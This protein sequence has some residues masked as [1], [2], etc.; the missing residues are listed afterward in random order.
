MQILAPRY[1]HKYL[2]SSLRKDDPFMDISLLTKEDLLRSIYPSIGEDALLYL[3]KEK[4]YQYDVATHYLEFLPYVKEDVNEKTHFLLSL[5]KELE[6][7]ELLISPINNDYSGLN[8]TIIGYYPNDFEL[9]NALKELNISYQFKNNELRKEEIKI[10]IFEKAEDEVYYVLNKI[11][12]LIDK[13]TSINDIYILRRNSSYDYYLRK[14][15]PKFGYQVNIKNEEK[16]SSTGAMKLF[17]SIYDECRDISTSLVKLKEDMKEDP[18]FN[19]VEDF[20]NQ[21]LD[22]ELP[23]EILRDY[24]YHKAKEKNLSSVTYD[25]AISVISKNIVSEDKII[26]VLGFAQGSYPLSFK[27]DKYFN[28]GELHK[29][30]RLNNKDKTKLDEAL[31]LD[32]FNSNNDFYFSFSKKGFESEFYLSP[33]SKYFKCE[34]EKPLLE[35]DFY[36]KEV[37]TLIYSGLKDL[38][39]Y[40]KE[41]GDN[42]LK[43]RDIIPISYNSYSNKYAYKANVYDSSSF[44][45]LSTT[46]LEKYSSCRYKFYLDNVLHIDESVESFAIITGKLAHYIFE[47]MRK[48]GFDFDKEYEAKLSEYSLKLS[49]KYVLTHNIKKQILTAVNAIKKRE[50]YYH[51]PKIYNEISFKY[52]LKDNTVIVG[53]A[54]NLVTLDNKYV[55]CIDYKTGGTKFDEAKL[56]FGLSSQLPTYSLLIK[57]DKRY[58]DLELIGLYI[59]NVL[60]NQITIKNEEDELIPSYLKLNGKSISDVSKI[61]EIDNTISS[62]KSSFINGVSLKKEG[63]LKETKYIAS[64]NEFDEYREI[65][66]NKLIEMDKNLR[67]NNFDIA[68]SY[69][70][71]FDNACLY[72]SYKDICFVRHDQVIDLSKEMKKDEQD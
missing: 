59:N 7:K 1:L 44:I 20:V 26:F 45:K 15:A 62:S 48:P 5:K 50:E 43:I 18:L 9:I 52:T 8:V 71:S 70:S 22:S 19:E 34:K 21:Y 2:L 40:Y 53:I 35:N 27:D 69:F 61:S 3:I 32:F 6:E 42:Y 30:N 58:Q 68:P 28:S 37:L 54:D 36:S 13:G 72:C 25:K 66:K 16:L 47:N 17:F 65:I 11:A 63:S 56:S 51:N 38:E 4:K 60:T 33:I 67:E 55:F 41:R 39:Y 23:Y 64:E 24:L 14:F 31:L 10:S 12:S 46:S 57:E 49:E 29:I